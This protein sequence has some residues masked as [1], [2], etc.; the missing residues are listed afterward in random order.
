[1][2]INRLDEII[3]EDISY[4][5]LNSTLNR[6]R[7]EKKNLA[8]TNFSGFAIMYRGL[9]LEINS[10]EYITTIKIYDGIN[11]SSFNSSIKIHHD[12]EED[13]KYKASLEFSKEFEKKLKNQ[14]HINAEF[15]IRIYLLIN[16]LFKHYNGIIP[17]TKK[18]IIIKNKKKFKKV[19]KITKEFLL[20]YVAFPEFKDLK[21]ESLEDLP[22]ICS[23]DKVTDFLL[24]CYEDFN[25][26]KVL[27]PFE[28]FKF[29]LDDGILYHVKYLSENT[30]AVIAHGYDGV[31]YKAIVYIDDISDGI[32]YI[33]NTELE[34]FN[35]YLPLGVSDIHTIF[36]K[37]IVSILIN[38]YFFTRY[39]VKQYVIKSEV[40]HNAT[41]KKIANTKNSKLTP[42]TYTIPS[43]KK[44]YIYSVSDTIK[45]NKVVKRNKPKYLK[46][47]W[48]RQGHYRYYKNGKVVWINDSICNRH[49]ET[50]A[51]ASTYNIDYEK[52]KKEVNNHECK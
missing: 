8:T 50:Q 41:N 35:Y 47:Q 23:N 49:E 9:I 5:V 42:K 34:F 36:T 2:N 48:I 4:E 44:V 19:Y 3:I 12:L 28:D 46:K 40:S 33:T 45:S 27:V 6:L 1:M 14:L 26:E 25:N 31:M 30:L 20:D 15:L 29:K 24:D 32:N 43:K 52:L 16:T 10:A 7:V 51:I 21:E 22:C 39:K 18:T 11:L 38:L 13:E 37:V 17:F